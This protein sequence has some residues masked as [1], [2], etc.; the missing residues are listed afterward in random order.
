MHRSKLSKSSVLQGAKGGAAHVPL[1]V[2]AHGSSL[3]GAN[4]ARIWHNCLTCI[5]PRA[6]VSRIGREKHLLLLLSQLETTARGRS[7]AQTIEAHGYADSLKISAQADA[8][9]E[10]TRAEGSKQAAE[11]P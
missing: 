7:K 5:E 2:S 6:R 11:R 4:F 3:C 10:V 1:L 9:A 8:S